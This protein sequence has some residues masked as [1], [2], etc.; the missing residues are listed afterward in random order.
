MRGGRILIIAALLL[1]LLWADRARPQANSQGEG[2]PRSGGST[3][4]DASHKPDRK[5][6][7]PAE[8]KKQLT[9]IAARG[10]M[11]AEV[12]TAFK[13]YADACAKAKFGS[14]LSEQFRA[15]VES[16]KVI[17][18]ALLVGLYPNYNVNV[19]KSLQRLHRSF[20]GE[21]DSHPHLALAFAFV[22]GSAGGKMVREPL[23]GYLSRERDVPSMEDSFE[24]YVKHERRMKFSLKKTPW[25]LLVY[26][27]DNDTPIAEREW[28]LKTYFNTR[29]AKFRQIYYDVPYDYSKINGPGQMG[30]NPWTLMNIVK[31][32]GVCADRAYYAS[33]VLK[34]I[35]V[36]SM[37]DCGIGERGGHAWVAWIIR[38]REDLD[39]AFAGRFTYDR[40]YTG[41]IYCPLTRR[42]ILDR[43]VQLMAAAVRRS[44]SGYLEALIGCYVYEMLAPH[45][46]REA[47]ELLKAAVRRNPLCARPWRVLAQAC[48]DGALPRK[49]G[50]SMYSFML[51]KFRDYP[52]LTSEVLHKIMSVRLKPDHEV[53]KKEILGNLRLLDDTF[54]VY[55]KAKRPDLA[56][57]LRC[58]QG[59]YL[60]A[61]GRN[62]T[63]RKLYVRESQKYAAEHYGVIELF[64]R[65]LAL[66]TGDDLEEE[67]LK[68]LE[69]MANKVPKFQSKF[70]EDYGL[71]N[72]AYTHVVKTY[73]AA[74]RAAG[75]EEEAKE[76]EK[77]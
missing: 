4:P 1:A 66:M 60:E 42:K 24:Y 73:V 36:A 40:Y 26:I 23:M 53:G 46:R 76:W 28:A 25:P 6:A 33:R 5:Q 64:D 63:A 50:E 49:D 68:Y 15:W 35:G 37:Y 2:R 32:G 75:R 74:L 34:S 13:Q 9:D 59:Q 19:P 38:R 22:C 17:H 57:K 16:N 39:M 8:L 20:P 45:E 44:Y 3:K 29:A 11:T 67:R 55:Q 18:D 14:G 69:T 72:R 7:T 48:V 54:R 52:D 61:V 58:L 10:Q 31:Y 41:E 43:E 21:T 47:P 30:D 71:V 12:I 65:A 62:D 77:R 70:N 51:R 56:V 27:V